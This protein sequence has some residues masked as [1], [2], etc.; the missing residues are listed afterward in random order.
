MFLCVF[1]EF[2]AF[3]VSCNLTNNNNNN[4]PICKAPE[5][6]HVSE[7]TVHHGSYGLTSLDGSRNS[8]VSA[9]EPLTH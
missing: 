2:I 7:L 9:C 1:C 5:Y 3:F 6:F 4:N 8:W